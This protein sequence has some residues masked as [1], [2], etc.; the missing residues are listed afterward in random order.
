M[1]QRKERTMKFKVIESNDYSYDAKDKNVFT[2]TK[3]YD[4]MMS[5][6][7]NPKRLTF[8]PV[9]IYHQQL[10]EVWNFD[11]NQKVYFAIIITMLLTSI[12][13]LVAILIEYGGI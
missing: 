9:E 10:Y 1:L 13:W 7:K 5:V 2:A 6:K 11:K 3:L 4:I 8:N 12:L